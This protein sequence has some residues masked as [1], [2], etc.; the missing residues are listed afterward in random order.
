MAGVDYLS[1]IARH[2]SICSLLVAL[3]CGVM[4]N[5]VVERLYSD[6]WTVLKLPIFPGFDLTSLLQL[7]RNGIFDAS[8]AGRDT[9]TSCDHRLIDVVRL[10]KPR[11]QLEVLGLAIL[12]D[13]AR[14]VGLHVLRLVHV[15]KRAHQL[16]KDLA[17]ATKEKIRLRKCKALNDW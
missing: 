9:A 2:L 13:L 1:L 10:D 17:H 3:T 12:A 15:A 6:L 16:R 8:V 11:D 4:V 14:L 7:L 5:V